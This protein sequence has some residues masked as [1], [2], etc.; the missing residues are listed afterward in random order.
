VEVIPND[1]ES[2]LEDVIATL[3]CTTKVEPEMIGMVQNARGK[4]LTLLLP[5]NP[6]AQV[7]VRHRGLRDKHV[8]HELS[9]H[10]RGLKVRF[11]EETVTI[12]PTRKLPLP[13]ERDRHVETKIGFY[14]QSEIQELRCVPTPD[15][16]GEEVD[17]YGR[18]ERK[19][20]LNVYVGENKLRKEGNEARKPLE[21]GEIKQLLR[22][23]R[24]AI[25]H[26]K[27]G[28]KDQGDPIPIA[29][30]GMITINT[31]DFEDTNDD[32]LLR[33]LE[34]YLAIEWL[35]DLQEGTISIRLLVVHVLLPR[36][37]ST[38]ADFS[39]QGHDIIEAWEI[40]FDGDEWHLAQCQEI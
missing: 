7:K 1:R 35:E 12:P 27:R 6:G 18:K 11:A 25:Q 3:N 16:L 39:V 33:G 21:R 22:K 19:D 26:E 30:T 37:W 8:R 10:L 28:M 36:N 9:G 24:A 5:G 34:R 29:M 14:L 32:E 2:W 17:I 31:P 4:G 13:A 40:F 23:M 15:G 38:R 20:R